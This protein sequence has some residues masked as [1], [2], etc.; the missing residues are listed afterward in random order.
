MTKLLDLAIDRMRGL[1]D[2][3]QNV[4]ASALITIVP[5]DVP[6]IEFDDNA[7]SVRGRNSN[8]EN[9]GIA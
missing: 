6:V 7:A 2:D 9:L 5:D 8:L 1:S 3:E 4:L